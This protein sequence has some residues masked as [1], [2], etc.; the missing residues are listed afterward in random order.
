[1]KTCVRLL[2]SEDIPGLVCLCREH[3]EFERAEWLE[4]ERTDR[5]ESM[6]LRAEDARCW[7]VEGEAGLAGFLS[8]M[9]ERS[10]WEA[11][12]YIHV[13]CLYVRPAYRGA[14]F[15]RS[16]MASAADWAV[17]E[18][19]SCMQWQTPAWN[20]AAVRFYNRFGAVGAEKIR[21]TLSPEK[22]V[23]LAADS[24]H[25]HVERGVP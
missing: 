3:A 21:Y 25:P 14:G 13:D 1:M 23:S 18:R 9:L 5:L 4:Y 10:T 6:L 20:S 2:R 8:A 15:G 11:A 12:R 24:T 17:R 7:V 19:V 22:C 16:L